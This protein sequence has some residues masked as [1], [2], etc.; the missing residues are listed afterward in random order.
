MAT[1][2]VQTGT[3]DMKIAIDS[4]EIEELN[5]ARRFILLAL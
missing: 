5:F 4:I 2:A 3:N 1:T